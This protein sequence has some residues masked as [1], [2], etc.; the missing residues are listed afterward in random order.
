MFIIFVVKFPLMKFFVGIILLA[1]SFS[2]SAQKAKLEAVM[3]TA[4]MSKLLDKA[5]N[6]RY[7]KQDS[8]IY[9][10]S[11][12]IKNANKQSL[13]SFEAKGFLIIGSIRTIQGEYVEALKNDLNALERIKEKPD[14][15]ILAKVINN[16][17]DDYSHMKNYHEA[18]QYFLETEKLARK[19]KNTFYQAIS[20]FNQGLV[21]KH[22]NQLDSASSRFYRSLDIS[23]SVKDSIGEAFVMNELGHI[24]YMQ[25][26][27]D[28]SLI[29]LKLGLKIARKFN[30]FEIISEALERIGLCY[31]QKNNLDSAGIFMNQALE[32]STKIGNSNL[33]TNI[34]NSQ[35]ELNIKLNRLQ[36]AE[37]IAN[38]SIKIAK[39]SHMGDQL[40]NSYRLLSLIY[41]RQNLYDQ[42]LSYFKIHSALKDSLRDLESVNNLS[43]LQLQNQ[44]QQRDYEILFLTTREQQRNSEM[45]KQDTLRNFLVSI[46][47]FM[48]LLLIS[49]YR[50]STKRRKLNLLLE[51]HKKGTE[52]KNNELAEL[53]KLKDK[54]I[55]ILAHD[56][57]SP[58]RSLSGIL[59]LAEVQGLTEEELRDLLK[60]I[61]KRTDQTSQL[62]D[63]LLEWTLL[64]MNRITVNKVEFDLKEKV[65]NNV[66]LLSDTTSK[67]LKIKIDIPSIIVKAD[68]NMIDL[69]IRNILSNSI[70]FTDDEGEIKLSVTERVK[71]VVL[72]IKDNGIGLT[73]QELDSIF[74]EKK[75]I[76]KTG[77]F[78]EPGTGLGLKLSKEF[79]EKNGGSIWVES[80][81]NQGCTFSFSVPKK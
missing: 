10:A 45:K 8:A 42:S 9:Y 34:L 38:Q 52:L 70:K 64:Q 16:I 79:V 4:Y 65:E 6:L 53:N 63:N 31:L 25:S 32:I 76:T 27:Y 68:E 72:S 46:L 14:S 22:L 24:Y 1:F 77:T 75:I 81:K 62:I 33:Q 78:N 17:G 11:E 13:V 66:K 54:F 67:K 58:I 43:N 61:K 28:S 50:S 20:T 41:E 5:N 48:S 60:N 71:D 40:V 57:R 12:V 49:L 51:R 55:S 44:L 36:I 35:V 2:L 21:F 69:A 7:S 56:L 30:E 18:Y 3:D 74:D 19:T 47:A 73:K 29:K 59:H 37:S 15:A 39:Q 23:L 26:K 80:E